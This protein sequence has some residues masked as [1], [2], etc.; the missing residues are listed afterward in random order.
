MMNIFACFG[1][2][3]AGGIIGAGF[4]M[5]QEAAQRRNQ[6]LLQSGRLNS[7]WGVMLG[8]GRRV[9]FLLITLVLIQLVCPLLFTPSTKWWV[10]GGVAGGYGVTLIRQLRQRLAQNG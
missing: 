9:A 4:G 1:A 7:G 10:S 5:I 2:L 6:K 3:A 8:S